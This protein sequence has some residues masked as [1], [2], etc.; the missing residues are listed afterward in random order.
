MELCDYFLRN[1]LERHRLAANAQS[2]FDRY[3]HRDQ[4]AAYQSPLDTGQRVAGR[5]RVS[6]QLSEKGP[7]DEADLVAEK[8]V[9]GEPGELTGDVGGD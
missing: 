1:P 2:F 7:K 8:L 3:L 6:A 5:R 9:L 4:L